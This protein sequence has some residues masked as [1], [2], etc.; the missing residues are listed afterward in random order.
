MCYFN[1]LLYNFVSK[2][3][4]QVVSF[5]IKCYFVHMFPCPLNLYKITGFCIETNN[6][7][8]LLLI[9][10]VNNT[11]E[12]AM[13]ASTELLLSWDVGLVASYLYSITGILSP[14]ICVESSWS[15]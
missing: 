5:L 4:L 11:N 2:Q 3:E 13:Q 7:F 6:Y 9:I 10:L 14:K 15:C 1:F 12:T 8:V